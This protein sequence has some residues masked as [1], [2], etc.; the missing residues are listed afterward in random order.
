MENN[1]ITIH[2]GE[3]KEVTMS[4]S[5]P[6]INSLVTAVVDSKED[7]NPKDIKVTSSIDGFDT[8]GF[9]SLMSNIV[10]KYL[11]ALKLENTSY[12]K[13]IEEISN[14]KP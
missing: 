1:T 14:D 13:V 3:K 2:L 6:D 8:N 10:S 11:N 12:E 9:T 5:N 4:T 7:I